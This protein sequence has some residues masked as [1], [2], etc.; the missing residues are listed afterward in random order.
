MGGYKVIGTCAKR[1]ESIARATG[2][3]ELIVLDE[4]PGTEYEDYTSQDIV[5]KVMEITNGVGVHAV[6]DGIGKATYEIALDSL[7]VRGIFVSF[8]N[9]SGAVPAYPP[10]KHI[11]KSSFMT[12]PKLLEYTR[13]REELLW[14]SEDLWRWITEGKLHVSVDKTFPLSQVAEGHDY[15]EAGRSKGKVVYKISE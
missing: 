1:K 15:L 7:A 4:V 11:G 3:D 6:I 13:T 5:K 8:G 10:L 12:R 14:R 9:A 2:V